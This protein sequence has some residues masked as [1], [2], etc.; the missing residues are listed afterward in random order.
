M[1]CYHKTGAVEDLALTALLHDSSS[2]SVVKHNVSDFQ[3]KLET[4]LMHKPRF[5]EVCDLFSTRSHLRK[6]HGG[7]H[8]ATWLVREAPGTTAEDDFAWTDQASAQCI[9]LEQSAKSITGIW[10]I[11]L[12]A[13]P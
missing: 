4:S 9:R 10:S 6:S 5:F 13:L 2:S 1:Q 11:C 3:K 12:Q 8:Y 7:A